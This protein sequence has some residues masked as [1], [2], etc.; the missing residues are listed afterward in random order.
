MGGAIPPLSQYGFMVWYLVTKAQGQLYLLP[1]WGGGGLMQVFKIIKIV[2]LNM[3]V[4]K[5]E[6]HWQGG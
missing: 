3:Y 4:C 1:I 5:Q 6:Q 2:I